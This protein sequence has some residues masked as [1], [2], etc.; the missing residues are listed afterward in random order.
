MHCQFS[1]FHRVLLILLSLNAIIAT[2]DAQ[3]LDKFELESV[4]INSKSGAKIAYATIY[5]ATQQ[6]GTVSNLEGVFRLEAVNPEDF[7]QISF[8]GFRTVQFRAS[9]LRNLERIFLEPRAI[10]LDEMIILADDAYLYEMIHATQKTQTNQVRA[11]KTYFSLESFIGE[12]QMEVVEAYYNGYFRGYQIDSLYLK[13]GR[14]ALAKLGHRYFLSTE[15]STA[16]Y[17]HN[18]FQANLYFPASPFEFNRRKMRKH[19]ELSLI[20]RLFR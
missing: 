14:I 20:S 2:S 1:S 17:M 15:T 13:T 5:N 16:I 6:T 4:V 18:L 8:I 10:E 11:A 12:K 9:E 3:S 7:I 19:F